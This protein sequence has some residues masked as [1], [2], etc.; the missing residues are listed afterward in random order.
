MECEPGEVA[1]VDFGRVRTLRREDGKLGY[2]NVLQVTL[3]FSRKGYPP[4]EQ[5]VPPPRPGERLASLRRGAGH[6][7][8]RQPQR[9]GEKGRLG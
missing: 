3:S 2:S 5:R 9:S 6:P 7:A 1:Q 8:R 4:P